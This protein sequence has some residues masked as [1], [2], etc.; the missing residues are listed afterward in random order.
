MGQQKILLKKSIKIA[1]ISQIDK[2]NN[3]QNQYAMRKYIYVAKFY[4]R[5][6]SVTK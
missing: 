5:Y 2:W 6:Q 4:S 1:F 3:M